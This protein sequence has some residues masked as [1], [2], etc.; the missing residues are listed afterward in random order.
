[1]NSRKLSF[2]G[3]LFFVLISQLG[4]A[5]KTNDPKLLIE[6]MVNAVGG[7]EQFYAHKD[8]ELQ[9]TFHDLTEGKRDVSIERYLFDGQLSWAKFTVR[10]K[11][12]FPDLE[13]EIIQGYNGKETWMTQ[14][15]QLI[16][17]PQALRMADFT[18][19]TNFYWFTMLFKLLDP[20]LNYAYKGTQNVD[21]VDYDLVEITFNPGVGDVQ[22]T[23]LLYLN[24][25]TH[26]VDQFLFT[27]MDFGVKEPFLMKVEYEEIAGLKLPTKRKY[28][29]ADWEG[30]AKDNNW[31]AEIS[32]NIKF[33]NGFTRETFEKP[34][35]P[36]DSAS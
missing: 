36:A 30:V 20:G 8:V 32:E 18:R 23:Y 1:M 2:F 15:G 22:D 4:C 10:E 6:Q 27:V 17:D 7:R 12:A 34:D 19:K 11:Y 13:G 24:P 29:A 3:V 14:N 26:L 16:A 35:E 33:N 5:K 9:Y 21:G 28:V 31:T 25:K